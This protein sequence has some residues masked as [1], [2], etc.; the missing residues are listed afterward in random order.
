MERTLH[1]RSEEGS[2]SAENVEIMQ[3]K[4]EYE[5]GSKRQHIVEASSES[6]AKVLIIS[7][8]S[9]SVPLIT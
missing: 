8:I 4:A 3:V 5:E 7:C 1:P 9:S 2:Q 6:E